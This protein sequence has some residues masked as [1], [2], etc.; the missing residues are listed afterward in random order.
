MVI[1]SIVHPNLRQVLP[2]GFEPIVKSDGQ[3][4]NDCERNASKRWLEEFRSEHPQLPTVIMADALFSNAPF[5][6]LLEEHRCHYILVCQKDDHVYLWNWF[7]SAEKPDVVEFEETVDTIHKRYRFMKDVPLN[8]SHFD[9]R[10]TVVFYQ[11]TYPN[12]KKATWRW[13]T[14]LEVTTTNVKEIVKG[15]RT[16]W[17]IENETFNTLKNQGYNFEHNYGHGLKTLRNLLAGLM[18]LV[19]LIDQCL[20]AVNLEFQGALKKL[21]SRIRFWRKIR[22]YF[23]CFKISTWEQLYGSILDTPIFVL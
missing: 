6:E 18:F 3:Q 13:M 7:W 9:R 20:E 22:S 19:F 8:E 5:I 1:G 23:E 12:G 2:I 21:V 10:V 14:D 11:E 16:R 17:K 4:K 15:G